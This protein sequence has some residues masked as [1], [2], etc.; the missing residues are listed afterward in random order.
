MAFRYP[1]NACFT[2]NIEN[3]TSELY[4][5]SMLVIFNTQN[6]SV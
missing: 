5:V 2:F 6:I 1:V 4:S 3:I